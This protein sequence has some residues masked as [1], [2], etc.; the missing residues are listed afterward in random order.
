M[1]EEKKRFVAL[2]IFRGLTVCFMII[3][4][5]PGNG[6][7]SFAPLQHAKWFGFTATDLVFPSFLFATGN[8]MYFAAE[9]W[10]SMSTGQVWGKI[11]KR[12]LLIFLL[13]VL[14][15]WFPFFARDA[16]GGWSFRP[17]SHIRI[18]GVLQRIAVAYMFGAFLV[19]YCKPKVLV[20]VSAALL[21]LY[22]IL[23]VTCGYPGMDSLSMYG[24]AVLR[25]D[26]FVMGPNHLYHDHGEL[27]PFDPEGLLSTIP[28]IVNVIVGYLV[29]RYVL[30]KKMGIE[31]LLRV[32]LVG[33]LLIVL[34]YFG[35]GIFP[36]GKKLWTSTFVLLT[37]GLDCLLL[38]AIIY[39][40]DVLQ[41]PFGNYFFSVFGKNPLV[42]YLFSELF[43][44]VL[45][46]V[47]ADGDT[48]VYDWLFQHLFV[49]FTPYLGSLI[50]AICYM[51]LC[52]SLGY[53]LDKKKIYIR[54]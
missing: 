30:Q 48:N 32:A 51:L 15:Y 21:V 43:A 45:F 33:F 24:N 28:A 36:I 34:A 11:L 50:Q 12:S 19:Y 31:A 16:A 23:M 46:T 5:T 14:M 17:L 10:L 37:C 18:M 4:N 13:G 38:V 54:V 20:W 53:V 9:R 42:I 3:V 22:Y 27:Y 25:L 2:D 39:W 44:T 1:K 8:A 41:K 7:T 6:D 35:N 47:H 29:G 52:W 49:H 26:T 40:T